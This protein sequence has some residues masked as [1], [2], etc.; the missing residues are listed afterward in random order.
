MLPS[1][2]CLRR[3]TPATA[4][5]NEYIKNTQNI[6]K[7]LFFASNYSANWS[8]LVYENFTPPKGPSTQLVDAASCVKN[9][10]CHD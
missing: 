1:G 9:V 5:V 4:T 10:Q 8:L 7:K 3:I 6:N 2:E